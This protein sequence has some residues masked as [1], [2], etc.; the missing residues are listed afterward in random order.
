MNSNYFISFFTALLLTGQVFSQAITPVASFGTNPGALNM[1]TYVPPGISGSAPLVVAMH[2]CTENASA[3]AAQTGWNKLAN[4]HKFYMVYPEQIAA[5]NSSTC[6]NWF[7]TTDITRGLGEA[8]SVKQMVDYMTSHYSID[9]K[10]IFVTGLSAGAGM[11][12]VMMATY[13]D[14]FSKGAVM[15]GLPY[16]ASVSS[17]TAFT[18]MN[19]GVS[20]TPAQW[21]ALV[22]GQNPGFT[23]PF[24]KMAIFHGSSDLTVNSANATELIKQWTNLNHADQVIDS[25]N[26]AFQGNTNIVQSIYND[27][28]NN[29]VVIYY[30]ITGMAHGI[31]VDTGA[32]PRQG[33]ATGT[34]AIKETNFHSTYWAADFFNILIGPYAVTGAIQVFPS[35]SNITYSVPLHAGSGY[36]WSV[37]FGAAILSGQGTNA[38]TVKFGTTSGFVQ[39]TETPATGCKLDPAKLYV[40]VNIANQI[41]NPET[42]GGK[43]YYSQEDNSIHAIDIDLTKLKSIV[44]YNTMGQEIKL[45]YVVE[46]NKITISG[47]PASGMYSVRMT[48]AEK[49]YVLKIFNFRK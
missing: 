32:C 28:S 47:L 17:L 20:K 21:G 23:N 44:A 26:S 42:S 37:P 24:P 19:G 36:I 13:P 9:P 29:P 3:Y 6:F 40:T 10:R 8:L 7:D 45:A 35:A 31:A 12:V 41:S 33:G 43:L 27:S 46:A 49:Q 38:I 18:A 22:R 15:A 4:L 2:G 14:V 16:K 48:I 5:N 30:K 39:V 1:Y 25:S 11:T 34:Y